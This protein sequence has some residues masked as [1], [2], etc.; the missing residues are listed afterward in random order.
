MNVSL[1]ERPFVAGGPLGWELSPGVIAGALS[2]LGM[3]CTVGAPTVFDDSEYA[4]SAR[5]HAGGDCICAAG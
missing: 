3:R 5:G 2:R 4:I 1:V